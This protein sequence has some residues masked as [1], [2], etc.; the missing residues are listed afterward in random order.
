MY[1]PNPLTVHVT[2]SGRL[3][4]WQCSIELEYP[5]NTLE[6]DIFKQKTVLDFLPRG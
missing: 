4:P 6:N 5:A 3:G 1:S 2:T